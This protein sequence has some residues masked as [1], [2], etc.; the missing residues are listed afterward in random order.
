MSDLFTDATDR[1]G[2]H[3][4]LA[5]RLRPKNLDEFVGQAHLVGPGGPLRRLL[6]EGG[7]LASMVFYGP[8]GT[9]KTALA[10]LVA[11]RVEADVE[12][13]N[14]VTAGV[15]EIRRISEAAADRL[16]LRGR[17]TMVFIDEI[18][19]FDKRQQDALLPD[20]EEGR[21]VLVGA[22]TENPSFYLT[23]ALASRTVIFEFQPL[24]DA[25]IRT[26]IQRGAADVGADVPDETL[27]LLVAHADGDARRALNAL[28]IAALTVRGPLTPE[29]VRS[30]IGRKGVRHDRA[31]DAH[32]DCASAFIKSMRG[33]DPDAAV[34]W[35]ARILEGGEDPRFIARR[36][37]ILAS[38]DIGNADPIALVVATAAHEAAAFVGMPEARIILAQV[39]TY[40]A[41]AP[42]SNAAYRAI[43]AAQADIKNGVVME[44]PMALR[45][46]GYR[47][48]E[49]LG[50]GEGYVYPHD[51]P[52]GHV[53]QAYL[54]EPRRYYEPTDRGHEAKILARLRAWWP[55]RY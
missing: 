35:L 21:I 19:R 23:S 53:R 31:G 10:H 12:V 24:A 17:R 11:E 37:A 55:D 44:V 3:R 40:L 14:A 33:G 9:G 29:A 52:G 7:P 43:H 54:P 41:C 26:I 34:Y 49:R 13:L 22:T 20:V 38:E 51:A 28:E 8:P 36:M 39:A 48:A 27:D 4:P 1:S 50:R 6:E 15:A 47:D 45:G 25:E 16:S 46:T 2:A 5:R 42:K 18:H 30:V 32:Y